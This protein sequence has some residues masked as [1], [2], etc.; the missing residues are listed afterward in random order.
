MAGQ[1][2]AASIAACGLICDNCDIYRAHSEP[3][4]AR[5]LVKWFSE[6]RSIVLTAESLKCG[7]CHG[8]R[9]THWSPDCWILK[10]CVD[11]RGLD[12]CSQCDEFPCDRLEQW[13]T[14]GKEYG[15]A[16][17]RLKNL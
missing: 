13:S 11:D 1:S 10:C 16:L 12:N 8:P 3:E 5:K 2:K 15:E 9:D 14:G 7:K 6:K 17:E 4:I